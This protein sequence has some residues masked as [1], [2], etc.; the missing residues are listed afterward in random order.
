MI[1]SI[2]SKSISAVFLV[3]FASSALALDF[4]GYEGKDSIKE[5]Q[6]GSKKTVAGIDFW[7]DGLPPFKFKLL[8]YVTDR[9]HKS[10]LFGMISMSSLET[11][12]AEEAK[13]VGGDGVI[14]VGSEAETTGSVGFAQGNMMQ[15]S[16]GGQFSGFGSTA[17][18]Q[19]QNSKYAVVQYMKEVVAAPIATP[20]PVV[21]PAV[22]TTEPA[23]VAPV[24][25][26]EKPQ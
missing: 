8:G 16:Y 12:V 9:R 18:V 15:R 26:D 1:H 20:A 24:Q 22:T 19:K 23:P 25:S 11:D 5:G 17:Q 10:G 2:L 6:G 4:V 13:K 14:I 3:L 21:I 7:S